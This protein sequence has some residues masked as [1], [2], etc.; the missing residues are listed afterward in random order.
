[1]KRQITKLR[2]IMPYVKAYSFGKCKVLVGEEPEVGWH[3]SISH[4]VRYPN[5]EEIR[6]ARYEF[7]PD[8]IT[9]AMFLPPK[10]EWVN[11]HNNCFHL[12][13]YKETGG[14]KNDL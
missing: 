14:N 10:A 4:P 8:N 5:W 13:E 7:C 3:L 9:M 11:I 6:D 2:C 12:Y 1:M